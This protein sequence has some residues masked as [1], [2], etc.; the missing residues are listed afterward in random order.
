[1]IRS[2]PLRCLRT[3]AL[4]ALVFAA[5]SHLASAQEPASVAGLEVVARSRYATVYA[6]PDGS[7]RAA[8]TIHAQNYQ[9]ADGSWAPIVEELT[10]S[11]TSGFDLECLENGLW[12]RFG[13]VNGIPVMEAGAH[14]APAVSMSPTGLV[15]RD[16]DG[17]VLE[18]IAPLATLATQQGSNTV[19]FSDLFG[20]G[21]DEYIVTA[22]RVKHTLWLDSAALQ[23]PTGSAWIG[24]TYRLSLPA[25]HTLCTA[26]GTPVAGTAAVY[27]ELVVVV[28]GAVR[29]RLLPVIAYD[30]ADE[31]G[32]GRY[33]VTANAD[34]SADITMEVDA[35]WATDAE[36][37]LPIAIDPTLSLQPD[38]A[39]GKDTIVREA[40]ANENWGTWENLGANFAQVGTFLYCLL[41]YDISSIPADSTIDSVSFEWWHWGNTATNEVLSAHVITS[42]WV[43]TSVTW[44][45]RPTWDANPFAK[46]TYPA[47]N[48]AWRIWSTDFESTVQS[49]LDGA[50]TNRG[51]LVQN[52]AQ[53]QFFIYH[54]SSDH[55]AN[56]A[57]RPKFIVDYTEQSGPV[58]D[59]PAAGSLPDGYIGIAYGPVAFAASEGAPAYT[60]SISGSLP[61]G[62]T[63]DT[64]TGELSGNPT[65]AGSYTFDVIVTDTNDEFDSKT[66]TIDV[67]A[68]PDI[69]SPSA[70][71]LPEA[72]QNAPTAYAVP[73]LTFTASGGAPALSWSA[74]GLPTGITLNSGSGV[75]SGIPTV[76]GTFNVDVLVTDGNG[77]TDAE[78][79]TLVVN[80]PIAITTTELPNGREKASYSETIIYSGGTQDVTFGM[81]ITPTLATLTIDSATGE[82][83]GTPTV[84]EQGVYSVDITVTDAYGSTNVVNFS[85]TID[86]AYRGIGTGGSNCG[87]ETRPTPGAKVGHGLLLLVFVIALVALRRRMA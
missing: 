66:Y 44:N 13:T 63:Q 49:W 80:E 32:A 82:I 26:D 59:S 39:A 75:L 40:G 87:C 42:D 1:M 25:G 81:V 64:S 2:L 85:L 73:T 51:F 5:F 71:A 84:G 28:D 74:T 55:T 18:T 70:G 35:A 86:E 19:N 54:W 46:L 30:S 72:T 61:P 79:Y 58:I 57:L 68:S 11:Q 22:D 14:G 56:V 15:S 37:S 52:T 36:R 47:G 7:R 50:I 8:I 23:V 78:S 4:L 65:T 9:R 3:V 83:S 27:G 33:M 6:L 24:G 48:G 16:A 76:S 67:Y 10:P 29:Y 43:E 69:T 41:Q 20:G 60:W 31:R 62:I 45:T 34:G 77:R 38:P 53:A 12:S 21:D 17:N